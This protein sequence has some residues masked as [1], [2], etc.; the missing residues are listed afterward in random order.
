MSAFAL[1]G[2]RRPSITRVKMKENVDKFH[3]S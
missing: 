1:P 2:E 3:L